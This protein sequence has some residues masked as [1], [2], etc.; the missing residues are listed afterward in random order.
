V[1]IGPVFVAAAVFA[2]GC[3]SSFDV[4]KAPKD[5]VEPTTIGL[6]RS[7]TTTS[8]GQ[9]IITLQDGASFTFDQG[10]QVSFG[11]GGQTDGTTLVIVV[12]NGKNKLYMVAHV[13]RRGDPFP[14]GCHLSL[15]GL[16]Y[17]EPSA[18]VMRLT[19][20]QGSDWL[21]FGIRFRKAPS[22]NVPTAAP[23]LA[24][25]FGDNHSLCLDDAGLVTFVN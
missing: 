3:W 11:Y 13:A 19:E 12:P 6:W 15:V 21:P 16:L 4:R 8:Q 24:P 23:D 17:D 7:Q 22:A 18:V 9:V 10:H 2:A 14:A 5:V 25:F 1:R 20:P